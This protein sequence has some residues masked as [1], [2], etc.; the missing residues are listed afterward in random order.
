MTPNTVGSRCRLHTLTHSNHFPAHKKFRGLICVV[1]VSLVFCGTL[2]YRW[3]KPKTLWHNTVLYV[4][5]QAI[6][7]SESLCGV[8]LTCQTGQRRSLSAL[9]LVWDCAGYR[10]YDSH[11]EYMSENSHFGPRL[12]IWCACHGHPGTAH[13]YSPPLLCWGPPLFQPN[14]VLRPRTLSSKPDYFSS[15]WTKKGHLQR[16]LWPPHF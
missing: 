16:F 5:L 4:A 9:L 7:T 14:K 6:R 13:T 12:Q 3:V 11:V 8:G 2:C 15:D 1:N 10:W